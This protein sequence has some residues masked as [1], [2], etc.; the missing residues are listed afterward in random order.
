MRSLL[1]QLV[2]PV[3]LLVAAA[4]GLQAAEDPTDG[5]AEPG[6]FGFLFDIQEQ[7]VDVTGVIPGG[8][9]A[10]AGLAPGDRIVSMDGTH[11]RGM[12]HVD[13]HELLA[14]Y[15]AGDRASLGVL[16]EG[17]LLIF[18]LVLT[19]KPEEYRLS[20]AE[21]KRH[22]R[23]L[24]ESEALETLL[25]IVGRSEILLVRRTAEDEIEIR[26]AVDDAAWEAATPAL[27]EIVDRASRRALSS[28]KPGETVEL[29]AILGDNSLELKTLGRSRGS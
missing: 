12:S 3:V 24:E 10:E 14:G 2:W 6:F 8:P 11:V 13:F 9:A 21:L 28:L 25:R 15:R 7:T 4:A 27:A 5:A 16:R 19:A 26:P 1:L 17:R 22:R 29:E 18:E 23:R 20:E